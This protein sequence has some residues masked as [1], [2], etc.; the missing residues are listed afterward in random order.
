[1]FRCEPVAEADAKTADAFHAADARGQFGAQ[2]AGVGRLVRHAANGCQTEV[3]CRRRVL[4]L[5]EVDPI[6]ENNR[7]IEGEPRLRTVPGNE[8][9]NGVIVGPLAAGGRQAVQHRRFGLLEIGEG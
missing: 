3:D 8:F 2:E 6:A 7:A 5:F 9:T 4:P 1:L